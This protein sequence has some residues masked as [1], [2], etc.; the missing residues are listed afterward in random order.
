M[1]VNGGL[2]PG[3][4]STVL[5]VD[6]RGLWGKRGVRGTEDAAPGMAQRSRLKSRHPGGVSLGLLTLGFFLLLSTVSRP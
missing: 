6:L 5:H 2:V 4:P 3:I 1:E